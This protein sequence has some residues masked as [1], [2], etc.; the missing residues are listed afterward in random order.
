[1]GVGH[2]YQYTALKMTRQ[3]SQAYV[4]VW[5]LYHCGNGLTINV[6]SNGTANIA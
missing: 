3:H 2:S 1:M 5:G 4:A 6:D